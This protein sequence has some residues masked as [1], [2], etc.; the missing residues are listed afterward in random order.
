MKDIVKLDND[1]FVFLT[2]NFKIT[3]V[4]SDF[5]TIWHRDH[6]DTT[7]NRLNKLQPTFDGG[8]IGAGSGP[9]GNL[10]KLNALGDTVW[11][12]TVQI[13]W[14]PFGGFSI[15]DLI[16]TKDSG[17]AFV[18]IFGHQFANSMIVKTNK[19]GYTLWTKAVSAEKLGKIDTAMD[20]YAKCIYLDY[21]RAWDPGGWFWNPSEDCAKRGKRLIK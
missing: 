13:F 9:D 21:G 14:G 18:A 15:R 1:D 12:K 11:A 4:D 8:F 6:L 2:D 3:K 16:Q 10:Y 19:F 20:A 17:Y 5:D 7:G